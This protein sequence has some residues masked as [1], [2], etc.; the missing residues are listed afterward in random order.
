MGIYSAAE[1][2]RQLLERLAGSPELAL[3]LAGVCEFDCAG[4]QLLLLAQRAAHAA[5]GALRL[6][7]PSAAVVE[8]LELLGLGERLGLAAGGAL[9]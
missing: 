6:L 9:P 7:S 2:K 1:L 3:D 4:V 8:A 5:G